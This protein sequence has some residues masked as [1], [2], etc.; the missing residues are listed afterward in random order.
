MLFLNAHASFLAAVRIALSGQ[1]PPTHMVLRG[2]LESALYSLI[3]SQN[4]ANSTVWLHRDKDRRRALKLYTARNA[5]RLLKHDPNLLNLLGSYYEAAIDFGAHPNFRSVANHM[6]LE[7]VDE[8][9]LVSLTYLHAV[10][11]DQ[12]I[13]CMAACVEVGLAIIFMSP[14][15]FP[16]VEVA[17]ECQ[18]EA[19]QIRGEF[20]RFIREAGHYDEPE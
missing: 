14:H 7:E 1:A 17:G 3:A 6:R 18:A 5:I 16:N 10:P 2:A 8:G 13:R 20:D 9:R 12:S 19:F 11:S 15:A 4:E